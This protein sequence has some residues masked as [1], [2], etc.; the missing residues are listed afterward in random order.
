MAIDLLTICE[1]AGRSVSHTEVQNPTWADVEQAIRSLN[2]S[3]RNDLYLTPDKS[4]LETYLAV[5]G[6]DGRYLVT[7]SVANE[8]FP[9]IVN[10]DKPSS[11]KELL[12]V[13]GQEGDYPANWIVD[14]ETALHAAKVFYEAGAFAA[15]A[16]WHDV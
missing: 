6:G 12:L 11:P 3:E 5:G 7:G 1:W 14:F 13:G 4:D 9:T 2:N 15:G 10:L 16:N 8:R